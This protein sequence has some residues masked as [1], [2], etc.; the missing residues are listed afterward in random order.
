MERRARPAED[1][2]QDMATSPHTKLYKSGSR[3][4]YTEVSA[5][6]KQEQIAAAVRAQREILKTTHDR[7]K[8]DLN[9]TDAVQLQTDEYLRAC[10]MTGTIPTLLGL[11]A[12]LGIS[13]QRVYKFIQQNER[14]P[15]A[16]FLE[17]FRTAAAAVLAQGALTRTLDNST[18][19]FLLKNSGQNLADRHETELEVKPYNP[20]GP[21]LTAE[22]IREKW[23]DIIVIDD[24]LPEDGA[25]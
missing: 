7:G 22:E 12:S 11:S 14:H 19:I 10:E 24:D 1:M 23:K 3:P 18:S 13:R 21:E 20:L 5:E 15:T 2:A 25:V 6:L 17:S 16:E 9:D 4:T 8:V